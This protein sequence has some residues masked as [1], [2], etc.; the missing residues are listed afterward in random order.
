MPVPGFEIPLHGAL[1]EPITIAGAPRTAVIL[2]GTLTAVLSL[3]L[4]APLIGAPLGAALYG[5]A[6][7]ATKRDPYA[8]QVLARHLR[9]PAYLNG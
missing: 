4:Q 5:A 8:L 2:I 6:L 7:W 9:Q 1:A 3:G